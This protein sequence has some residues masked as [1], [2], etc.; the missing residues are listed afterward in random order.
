MKNRDPLRDPS[1]RKSGFDLARVHR[2]IARTWHLDHFMVLTNVGDRIDVGD[3]WVRLK[4]AFSKFSGPDWQRLKALLRPHRSR[5][6]LL[7][8][9]SVV[10][11]VFEAVILVIVTRIGLTIAEGE[12]VT[13]FFAGYELGIT[14]ALAVVSVLILIRY[15][16]SAGREFLGAQLAGDASD[17]LRKHLSEVFLRADWST[18]QNEPSGRLLQLSIS[19]VDQALATIVSLTSAVTMLFNLVAMIAITLLVDVFA[20][21]LVLAI[22][23]G[24]AAI[25]SPLRQRIRHRSKMSS[26]IQMAFGK[27]ISELG[28]LTLEMQ[29]FGVTDDFIERIADLSKKVSQARRDSLFLNGMVLHSYFALAFLAI[30]FGLSIASA[31]GVRELSSIGAILLVLLRSL[32][33]GRQLQENVGS[34]AVSL[35][36]LEELELVRRVFEEHVAPS[37]TVAIEDLENIIGR[38]VS[39]VYPEG[40][41]A[42]DDVSFEIAPGELIGVIG[43]S[44]SGKSTLVQLLLGLREPSK[45]EITIGGVPVADIDRSSWTRLVGFVSQDPHLFTGTIEENIEFFRSGFSEE[46]IR[47]AATKANLM[48]EIE[49]F[50]QA[51]KTHIGE[52]GTQLSGGQ[53]QRITIA[54][55]LIGLPKL[56][57]LD[58]PTSS[59]DVR[60]EALIR[61][62][63]FRLKG[64][65]TVVVIAHRL[66]TL[67]MCDRLMVIQSGR[68]SAFDTPERL[69]VNNDFYRETL[70]ISGIS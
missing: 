19:Y 21:I 17:L 49:E 18:Q 59:L 29:T 3:V 66:S 25:L 12:E 24:L 32:S 67:D 55:A 52:R 48:K 10:G 69:R 7:A 40:R 31:G 41:S 51:F 16:L 58:E 1:L 33:Y 56:L 60:S 13:P 6:L 65:V 36:Y 43:P 68:I 57:I 47:D 9:V 64:E 44:G 62:T 15:L 42:L 27:E 37:G 30:V 23:V 22:L 28:A 61:D 26:T 34:L 53:R 11:G 4:R 39:Y 2:P 38:G 45:G 70:S 20:S 35:P 5:A 54:R 50:P 46:Q 8:L 63:L 14:W